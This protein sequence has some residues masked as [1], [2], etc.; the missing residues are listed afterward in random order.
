MNKILPIILVVVLSGCGATDK[1]SVV[2]VE[3]LC[4][5]E[6]ESTLKTPIHDKFFAI[7]F[8]NS[9]QAIISGLYHRGLSLSFGPLKRDY[10]AGV[11][12]VS[13]PVNHGSS[14]Y[15][16]RTSLKGD[17][18]MKG[19][20]PFFCELNKNAMLIMQDKIDRRINKMRQRDRE[21]ELENKRIREEENNDIRKKR[22]F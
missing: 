16:N 11:E 5:E 18:G 3:L 14:L 17:F 2:G 8:I 13:A 10:S 12:M 20:T 19:H 4:Q 9:K 21:R 1:D 6:K 22:Q 15:L 7:K